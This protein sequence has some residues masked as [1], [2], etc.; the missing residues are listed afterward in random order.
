MS[1]SSVEREAERGRR[2]RPVST[3]EMVGMLAG[4]AS[5][6]AACAQHSEADGSPG[7]LRAG[8]PLLHVAAQ[9]LQAHPSSCPGSP[10]LSQTWQ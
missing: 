9:L 4:T 3:H 1:P 5:A 2:R 7:Q 8:L 6:E 10:L